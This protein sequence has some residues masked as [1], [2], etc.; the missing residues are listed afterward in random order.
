MSTAMRVLCMQGWVEAL[1]EKRAL[2][3]KT[4]NEVNVLRAELLKATN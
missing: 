3:E 1:R 2:Q 4:R